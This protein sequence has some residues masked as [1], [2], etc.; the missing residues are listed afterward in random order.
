MVCSTNVIPEDR[1]LRLP[2]PTSGHVVHSAC[3]VG[4]PED[5]A[6]VASL[7]CPGDGCGPQHDSQLVFE[8]IVRR[9][10]DASERAA[11]LTCRVSVDGPVYHPDSHLS[12]TQA[13]PS[14]GR[15]LGP[16]SVDDLNRRFQTAVKI[17][18]AQRAAFVHRYLRV[19]DLL[20][21][22]SGQHRPPERKATPRLLLKP[23]NLFHVLPALL[24][25]NDGR[26]SRDRFNAVKRG[27]VSEAARFEKAS[28][29]CRCSGSVATAA[30]TLL[31]KAPA[32]STKAAFD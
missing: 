17:P 15:D 8:D 12:W 2:C 6:A 5:A 29:A 23:E 32:P 26:V 14:I 19:I 16:Y 28:A 20:I 7:C 21:F 22:E 4:L 1:E 13:S 31:A 27:S 25:A 18:V 11:A 10:P 3:A 24:L 30:R 9:D